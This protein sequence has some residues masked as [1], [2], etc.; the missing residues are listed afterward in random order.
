MGFGNII[1][2][3]D[4]F[5]SILKKIIFI[6]ASF[7]LFIIFFSYKVIRV[8]GI[9][10][11]YPYPDF[12]HSFSI[13]FFL[14]IKSS[15][16]PPTIILLNLNPFDMLYVDLYSALFL[17]VALSFPLILYII[18]SYLFP[19]LY[20]KERRLILFVI[21]PSVFLFLL[22]SLFAFYIILPLLFRVV[23]ILT[24]SFGVD[25]TMSVRSFLSFVLMILLTTGLSFEL[26]VI[27]TSLSYLKIV[28][29]N[30]WLKN[31][32]YAIVGSFFIA[33]LISPGATGG[34]IESLIGIVLS[35]LYLIGALISKYL[36]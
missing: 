15:T 22:G 12:F 2:D 17:S 21:G 16:L 4:K 26:P 18:L 3:I 7:F 9:S 36:F 32:R 29:P 13:S 5:T 31:W 25:P 14:F 19:A 11:Y 28:S 27:I 34:L 6:F 23:I 10:L 20:Q 24:K 1:E 30:T 33:L 35:T 8:D